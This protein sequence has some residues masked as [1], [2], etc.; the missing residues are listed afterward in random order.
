MS[1]CP[2]QRGKSGHAGGSGLGH[3]RSHALQQ[4][5][6][7]FDHFVGTGEESRRHDKAERLGGLEVDAQLN[8][9]DPLHRQSAGF[10]PSRMRPV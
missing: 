4:T 7:L 1:A 3:K 2:Q 10:L 5:V 6:R 9:C 8:F